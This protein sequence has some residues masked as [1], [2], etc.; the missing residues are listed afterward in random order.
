MP[1]AP[2][3]IPVVPTLLGLAAVGAL[4]LLLLW[5]LRRRGSVE[6]VCGRCGY[7]VAGLPTF[8]CPECGS[9]LRTVGIDRV[10]R[11]RAPVADRPTLRLTLWLSVWTCFYGACYAMVGAR[12]YPTSPWSMTYRQFEYGLVDAYLWPYEGRSRHAVSL[13]PRSDGY[14]RVTVSEDRHARFRG[15]RRAPE[16]FWTGDSAPVGL[17]EFNIQLQLDTV[18]GKSAT[19]DVR[20]ADLSWRYPDPRTPGA[21]ASGAGPID[22]DSLWGWMMVNGVDIPSPLVRE[23]AATLADLVTRSA[24]SG[25][26]GGPPWATGRL[27]RISAAQRAALTFPGQDYPFT[28]S[29][30]VASDSY[31]PA[32]SIYWL[33]VPFGLGIYSYGTNWIFTRHRKL[34]RLERRRSQPGPAASK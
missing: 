24:R 34:T 23:E 31:G 17:V 5:W 14:R 4:G 2:R 25:P 3:P 15:W 20:P 27:E 6:A 22:G 9:D 11:A 12:S 1:P 28:S 30:G 8:T 10:R 19:L 18:D 33:S 7:P 21:T 29:R 16:I 32:I 13:T 26:V